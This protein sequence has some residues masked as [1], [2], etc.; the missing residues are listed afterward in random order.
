MKKSKILI[1][2]TIFASLALGFMSSFHFFLN[3]FTT[4]ESKKPLNN[5][6]SISA[7]K[8]WTFMVYVDA[9][10]NLESSGIDDV[11]E[12][13]MIGSDSNINIVV[14]LDRIPGYD[15]SNGDW[16]GT[17]RYYITKDYSSGTI[18]STVISDLGEVNMGS[19]STL[20][21]FISWAKST[22]PANN[23]ALILWDHGSGIM[24]GS[25]PGGVCWDDSNGNDH[26]T[27]TEI[28][29]VAQS[30]PVH[31]I[32]FDAC[33]MGAVEVDYQLKDIVNVVVGS[34]E[35]EPGEGYPYNDILGWLQLN[36]TATA[37]QLGQQIV[38]KYDASY[39]SSYE[40][41]QAAFPALTTGFLNDL[42]T[43]IDNLNYNAGSEGS[44]IGAARSASQTFDEPSYIDL[45]DFADEIGTRIPALSGYASS[46]KTA[47]NNIVIEEEHS[48]HYPGAHGL[49]IYFPS[50]QSGYSTQYESSDFA[51]N[52]N[53]D[54]FL[55]N[56]YS[57][58]DGS[59]GSVS[60]DDEYEENDLV[61]QAPLLDIGGYN[62]VCNGS[63]VDYFNITV[64][65][66]NLIDIGITFSNSNG[67]LDLYLYNST[68]Y[69]VDSSTSTSNS[70]NV[71]TTATYS[72]NY[73][74]KVDQ[75]GTV[76]PY[77]SYFMSIDF[78]TDD[79][80]EDNDD[81]GTP[82]T[83]ST[84]TTYYNLICRDS[85]QYAFTCPVGYLINITIWFDYTKGDLDLYYWDYDNEE[86]LDESVTAGDTENILAAADG[87][88]PTYPNWYQFEVKQYSS[89][90]NNYTMRVEISDV[91]DIHEDNDWYD[92]AP[93]LPY[94]DYYNLVCMDYD[95]YN[96]SLTAGTWINITLYFDTD[97]GDIDIYLEDPSGETVGMGLSFSDNEFVFYYVE[98]SAVYVI[99]VVY[100]DRLNLDYSMHIHTT[101][102]VWDD[103]LEDN[104]W[105]DEATDATIITS[106]TNLSAIDWDCF[107]VYAP[108]NYR[109]TIQLDYNYSIGNLDLY[110]IYWDPA[111]PNT[112]WILGVS[113]SIEDRDTL[114]IETDTTGPIYFLVYLDE[115]NM[116][117][118]ITISRTPLS[119]GTTLPTSISG[120]PVIFLAVISGFAIILLIKKK[121]NPNGVNFNF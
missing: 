61:S 18:S 41:T 91:D 68:G 67:D 95:F 84:G 17:K 2:F 90:I 7:T 97:M 40:I 94:G 36:P 118:N 42:G 50:T 105:F 58:H 62:L 55:K 110:E 63:D 81:W 9:D 15:S 23:Y 20:S 49:T 99:I 51:V 52:T 87:I 27:L 53:W 5:T 82:W 21:S 114:V 45:W 32:G 1:L 109:V 54:E 14:Q 107:V 112:A 89:A 80:F 11:N 12:M 25:S 73:T 59:G 108:A 104:D 69:L 117:Y 71:G 77:Q 35:T 4:L 120:Y 74:I 60:I 29:S 113:S 39:P 100:Y 64:I 56:Y 13:E 92:E 121:K 30:N 103:A 106:Y 34:E 38:L 88:G 28:K 10:N 57:G 46:L 96:V 47:I 37:S 43:F 8:S 65:N 19:P 78:G 83:I 102:T 31:L 66:G 119:G 79:G 33:L 115:I 101:T 72:G 98:T 111:T 76:M 44:N 22:Y 116:G 26:L 70:E 75:V 85:D 6:P 48:S 16:T 24:W 3:N 93:L 86:I